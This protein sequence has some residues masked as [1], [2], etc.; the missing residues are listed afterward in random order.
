MPVM[1]VQFV[2]AVLALA[3]AVPALS[4][5]DNH[6]TALACESGWGLSSASASCQ[7]T[8]NDISVLNGQCRIQA[9]CQHWVFQ[10][11]TQSLVDVY[12]NND[13]TVPLADVDDL[14]NCDGILQVGPC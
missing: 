2:L 8:S 12:K 10:I 7:S 5:A 13:L 6:A 11:L 1:R 14:H 3:L 4:N 9:R